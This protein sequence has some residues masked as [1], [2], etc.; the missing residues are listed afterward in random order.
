[1]TLGERFKYVRKHNKLNQVDFAKILGISQT[2]VSKIE[3]GIENPS[4]TLLR[5]VSYMFAINLE[6]LKSETGTPHDYKGLKGEFDVKKKHS[7][8]LMKWM[9]DSELMDFL[10]SFGYLNSICKLFFTENKGFDDDCLKSLKHVM[11]ALFVLTFHKKTTDDK[12]CDFQVAIL[13][14]AV[15]EFIKTILE[16]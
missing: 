10:D 4:E 12:E 7:E 8:D 13:K 3:K 14:N 9:N 15:D 6:W 16:K 5:F 1:M 2:H 11:Q